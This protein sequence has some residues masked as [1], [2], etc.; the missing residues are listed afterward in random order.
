MDR[1]QDAAP[2]KEAYQAPQVM[3]TYT[4][5]ELADAIRPHGSR[6]GYGDPGCGCGCG[7]S[8]IP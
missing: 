2:G 4:K 3:A 5:D 8:G 1:K 7:C 6:I